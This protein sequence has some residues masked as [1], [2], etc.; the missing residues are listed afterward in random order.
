MICAAVLLLCIALL[1]A[2][3]SDFFAVWHHPLTPSVLGGSAALS[4]V[5]WPGPGKNGPSRTHRRLRMPRCAAGHADRGRP[6]DH[7]YVLL[8]LGADLH[9]VTAK[10]VGGLALLCAVLGLG[11]RT[12]AWD[13]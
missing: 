6:G 13:R 10:F 3:K 11:R 1:F 7:R 9:N 12:V 8:V 2:G 4:V 5:G